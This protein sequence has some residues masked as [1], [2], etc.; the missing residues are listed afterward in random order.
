MS[1]IYFTSDLHFNHDKDFIFTCV[2]MG[3]PHAITIV[4]NV[5]DLFTIEK[6]NLI[7]IIDLNNKWLIIKHY[8]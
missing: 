8:K 1:Q 4:E 5:K 3:N 6:I 2:S 7:F